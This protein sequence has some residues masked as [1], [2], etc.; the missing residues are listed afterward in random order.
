[1]NNIVLFVQ[2]QE[3]TYAH[4]TTSVPHNPDPD[5]HYGK[6]VLVFSCKRCSCLWRSRFCISIP[7][8][9]WVPL[10]LPLKTNPI[11][12][13]LAVTLT[14]R[15]LSLTKSSGN[16]G[17]RLVAAHQPVGHAAHAE[18]AEVHDVA[19]QSSSFVAENMGHLKMAVQEGR[20]GI[21]DQEEEEKKEKENKSVLLA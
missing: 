10:L 18:L 17:R 15:A 14:P 7:R 19:G 20:E 4:I 2:L 12:K 16:R 11:C 8:Q 6:T 3:L 21:K 9:T 13:P 1:M 5:D